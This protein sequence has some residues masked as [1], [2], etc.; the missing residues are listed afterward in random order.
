M[1]LNEFTWYQG[2]L[3]FAL[4]V[5]LGAPG[6]GDGGSDLD[7]LP[8]SVACVC[9]GGTQCVQGLTCVSGYC[10][11]LGSTTSNGSAGDADSGDGDSGDGDSGDGDSGDGDGDIN[12]CQEFLDCVE[13][14]TPEML[15]SYYLLYGPE[16]TCYDIAGLD[17]EDCW[18]E[19]E[20]LRKALALAFP[21]VAE[22]GTP[23]CGNGKLDA[24]EMCDSTDGC[25]GTCTYEDSY[26]DCSPLTQVGCDPDE[27]CIIQFDGANVHFQ[28][29]DSGDTPHADFNEA[30]MSEDSCIP[31][32]AVC[33][34]RED[35]IDDYC[36]TPTCYLGETDEPFG[37]CPPGSQC[38]SLD[39]L[40]GGWSA[41]G[42]QVGICF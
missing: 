23:N 8:G 14:A 29:Y 40:Y 39:E 13:V 1:Q 19:C 37:T 28:C 16:G 4:G 22:C 34:Y 36:C 7:C 35:C 6:C 21:D 9:V 10:V 38:Y 17:E 33:E 25:T 15:S 3:G 20:A 30:C 24:D 32:N 41:V 42:D 12:L 31:L 5:W 2:L 18:N 27:R 11:D 26:F